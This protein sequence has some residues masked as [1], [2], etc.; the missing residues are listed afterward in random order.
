MYGTSLSERVRVLVRALQCHQYIE[1]CRYMF[2]CRVKRTVR[3]PNT[4]MHANDMSVNLHY[5]LSDYMY[6][7][8]SRRKLSHILVLLVILD[9]LRDEI[10]WCAQ[11]WKAS[12]ATRTDSDRLNQS[13]SFFVPRIT[14][15]MLECVR[16]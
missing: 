9:R 1:S 5:A 7:Y 3:P 2:Q 11:P 14:G 15:I 4:I 10:G 6:E 13:E 8:S 12:S 16:L